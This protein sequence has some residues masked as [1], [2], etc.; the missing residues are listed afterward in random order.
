MTEA[1]THSGR[2]VMLANKHKRMTSFTGIYDVISSLLRFHFPIIIFYLYRIHAA[3][4]RSVCTLL[5]KLKRYTHYDYMNVLFALGL[6]V[7]LRTVYTNT[8]T[9]L[10]AA[11]I[12]YHHSY[13]AGFRTGQ[14]EQLQP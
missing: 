6:P 4:F 7:L 11:Y 2:Y 1:K 3:V 12:Q 9:F 5:G 14:T 10:H 13:Q 8:K